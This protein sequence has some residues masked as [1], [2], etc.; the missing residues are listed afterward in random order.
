MSTITL[1][2]AQA[3]LPQLIEHL[4]P[5][6][7]LVITRNARTVATQVGPTGDTPQPLFGRDRG[8]VVVVAEDDEHVTGF[9]ID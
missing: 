3:Q 6:E 7:E 4:A 1:K 5:G 9:D 2:E 8:K